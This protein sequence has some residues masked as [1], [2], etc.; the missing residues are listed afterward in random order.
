MSSVGVFG[1]SGP[2]LAVHRDPTGGRAKKTAALLTPR[3]P[4]DRTR[5]ATCAHTSRERKL[6]IARAS[7]AAIQ[8]TAQITY[9][10]GGGWAAKNGFA[11][12][13]GPSC[14]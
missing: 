4:W 6:Q 9:A 11:A 8:M 1:A 10:A 5:T 13:A 7:I 2:G 12:T 3:S 14:C